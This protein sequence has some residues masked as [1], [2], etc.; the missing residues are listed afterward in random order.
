MERKRWEAYAREEARAKSKT[1]RVDKPLNR[2]VVVLLRLI[3][4][5]LVFIFCAFVCHLHLIFALL[6][7]CGIGPS[8]MLR[9]AGILEPKLDKDGKETHEILY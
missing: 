1:P 7:A 9:S 2:G 6:I 5:T 8:D 3:A 4:S